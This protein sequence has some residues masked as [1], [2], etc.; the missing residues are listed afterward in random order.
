MSRP[1]S[2]K[3]LIVDD[4]PDI[5]E[6]VVEC[7]GE[8]GL[9]C[10]T[11]QNAPEAI[12][13]V[14]AMKDI[15]IVIT[16]IR[17]PGMDGLEMAR[18]LKE[19]CASTRDLFII[20][21]TGHAA[22]GEAIKAL[23]LGAED[24]LTKP[25]SFDHLLH[26]VKRAEET[27]RLRRKEREFYDRLKHDVA[28]KTAD[29]RE[30]NRI[31]DEFLSMMG[32]ELRTPLNIINGF[33]DLL[34]TQLEAKGDHV[35]AEYLEHI[36]LSAQ[37][38]GNTVDNTLELA[39]GLNGELN[40][41]PDELIVAELLNGVTSA[42]ADQARQKGIDVRIQPRPENCILNADRL[43][44]IKALKC[45][46]ENAIKFSP[47]KSVVNISCT[48]G[49]KTCR[50]S[51][52]DHGCGMSDEEIKIALQPLR[53]VDGTLSRPQEGSG[54]GLSLARILVERQGGR[55]EIKST[56]GAGLTVAIVL[57]QHR[58]DTTP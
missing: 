1:F 45:L 53:Q 46:L 41:V 15:D 39:A 5:V 21:V 43:M 2:N 12:A 20:V 49:G 35:G 11:A 25:I 47:P 57:T 9:R 42:L 22:M 52:Q 51:I 40:P 31:K 54:I 24:F 55:L 34:K 4:E 32:H 48:Q 58:G 26:A 14:S 37:R 56:P 30:A 18:T 33:A 36:L 8:E 10:V 3:V 44:T 38:L 27:L 23:K 17:M 29:L 50:I 7:L 13:L 16:D 19:T 28:L 6:E